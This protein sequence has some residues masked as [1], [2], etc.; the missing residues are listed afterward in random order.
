MNEKNSAAGGA[1]SVLTKIYDVMFLSVL[2][3]VFCVPIITIGASTTALYYTTAKVL[4]KDAGYVWKEFWR[5]FKTNLVTGAIYTAILAVVIFVLYLGFKV[6]DGQDDLMMKALR[7]VYI[8]IAFIMAC[9]YSFIFPILS[10]FTLPKFQMFKMA[11]LISIK[12]LPTTVILVV[13]LLGAAAALAY[14]I[15]LIV[16]IPAVVSLL[17]SLLI[18]KVFKRYLPKPEEGTP[19]EE[20]K[21]YQT[22]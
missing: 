19:I 14:L 6:T 21:W 17:S 7:Y 9:G 8:M 18:E 11:F 1:F 12:H 20:L 10:R 2:W 4:R 16:F 5:A 13:M 3:A 22:F 15:P